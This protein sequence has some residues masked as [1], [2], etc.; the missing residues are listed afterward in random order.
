[1]DLRAVA[2]MRELG[3]KING[4]PRKFSEEMVKDFDAIIE[5]DELGIGEFWD[6]KRPSSAEDYRKSEVRY[7]E[8]LK[9]W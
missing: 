5:F 7:G 3:L 9:N 1:M 2:T 4:K 6:I 8:K